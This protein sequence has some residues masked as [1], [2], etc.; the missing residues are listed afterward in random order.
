MKLHGYWRSSASYR[1][2]IALGLKGLAH[3]HHAVNLKAGEHFGSEHSARNAQPFVP[4]LELE[5]GTKL[6]QSLAIMDYLDEKYP[7]RA[8]LP[9]DLILRAKIRAAAQ[10]IA[11]DIA[12]I[13]NLRILIYI[14]AEYAQ[15]G[16]GAKIWAA[17]W[18]SEGFK[19]LE[20]I[21]QTHETSCLMTDQPGYFECCLIP[22]IYNANRFGVDMSN[23]PRLSAIDK[24]LQDHPVFIKASPEK[25]PDATP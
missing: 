18:I 16:E 21:A 2:R 25:Q 13:Q 10:I 19:S 11:A 24:T 23:F 6:T 1:V 15:E 14:R 17:H 12:P 8:L 4:V 5:D 22:Q 7:Q 20:T 3:K 9:K